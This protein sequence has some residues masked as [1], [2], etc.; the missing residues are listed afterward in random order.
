MAKAKTAQ[1]KAYCLGR[2]GLHTIKGS[3][4]NITEHR[5]NSKEWAIAS[6]SKISKRRKAPT[7]KTKKVKAIRKASDVIT[8]NSNEIECLHCGKLGDDQS[9]RISLAEL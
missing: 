1:F 8:Y 9:V 2:K 3:P 5:V 4:A 6:S 7:K